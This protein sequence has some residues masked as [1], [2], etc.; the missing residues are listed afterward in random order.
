M[1]L[2]RNVFVFLAAC[3]AALAADPAG[4]SRFLITNNDVGSGFANTVSFY[5][6]SPSGAPVSKT[7]VTTGGTGIGGGIFAAE[8][9]LVVPSGSN[10]CVFASDAG[11]GDVAGLVFQTQTVTGDFTGSDTDTGVGNGIGLASNGTYVYANF[12]TSSTIGTFQIQSGCTLSFL[13]DLFTVG[14]NGGLVGGMAVHGN[15]MVVTYGDGS[16]ESFDLSGGV[17]V[18]HGDAQVSTGAANGHYPN[19][20]DITADGNFA[21][22]GD[23]ST[24]TTLEVS[25]ISTGKLAPTTAYDLGQGWNSGKVRLSPD[26]SLIYV[27]NDSGGSVSASFF[28]KNTGVIAP[29]CTS[30]ALSGF[31]TNFA[32]VGGVKTQLSQGTGGLLYVPEFGL[33][34]TSSI[35]VVQLAV[36]GATCT[37]TEAVNSPIV[38]KG[39]TSNLFSIEVYPGRAF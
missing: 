5:A 6:L 21:I 19:G 15:M 33:S 2:V 16:I 8:R 23:A 12:T 35:A 32:Y 36:S 11:S 37:L 17:P 22:F 25:D 3:T 9:L 20:I 10:T 7:L 4:T 18:S 26:E 30:T 13:G 39:D 24:I 31:Y 38:D 14:L 34:G 27:A 1:L 28:N 29:G